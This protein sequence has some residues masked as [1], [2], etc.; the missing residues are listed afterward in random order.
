MSFRSQLLTSAV[1]LILAAGAIGQAALLERGKRQPTQTEPAASG[2]SATTASVFDTSALYTLINAHRK[3]QALA[4]LSPHPLLEKSAN[5]KALDMVEHGYFSHE[6]VQ[7]R[8]SWY[9]FEEAGYTFSEAGENLAF[10]L[11][12][13]YQV[14]NEW[15][16]SEKHNAEL[17]GARYEHM[18]LASQC[19]EGVNAVSNCVVV[20]HLGVQ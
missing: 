1:L 17:L 7:N 11:N 20:L 13:P 4:P 19:I 5:L 16:K 10:N 12:T 3:E 6:D 2:S 9:L 18:G 8:E 15:I 14:L